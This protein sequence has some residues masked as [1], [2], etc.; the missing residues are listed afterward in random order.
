MTPESIGALAWEQVDRP[1]PCLVLA[2]WA[3][4]G[5]TAAWFPSWWGLWLPVF[6]LLGAMA[7]R[8]PGPSS[9]PWMMVM[10]PLFFAYGMFSYQ[11]ESSDRLVNQISELPR[12]VR[13]KLVPVETPGWQEAGGISGHGISRVLAVDSG[14]GWRPASGRVWT[15]WRGQETRLPSYG[16]VAVAGGFLE[17]PGRPEGPGQLDF[18]AYLERKGIFLVYSVDLN[19]WEETGEFNG[20]FF[21]QWAAGLRT[22]MREVLE[23][24]MD[25]ESR[26]PGLM[27]AMLFGYRDGIA[28]ELIHDFTVTGTLHLFAVSG[29]NVGVVLGVFLLFLRSVGVIRWRWGWVAAPALL[30]F[31]LATGMESSAARA[32]VMIVL[33]LLA[34]LIYRP[35]TPLNILGAAALILW[36]VDPRQLADAGF[37]LSFLVLLGLLWMGRPL[38]RGLYLPWRPDVFVPRSRL[39][40]WRRRFDHCVAMSCVLLASSVV[41]WV[42]SAPLIAYLFGLVA[43]VTVLSN[44]FV[45]PLA[46]VVVVLALGSVLVG[47]VP[48]GVAGLINQL[49]AGV[50]WVMCGIIGQ[51]ATVPGGHVYLE[52]DARLALDLFKVTCLS[53]R[54]MVAAIWQ[55]SRESKVIGVGNTNF[56]DYVLNPARQY[57]GIE[58]WESVWVLQGNEACLGAVPEMLSITPA[59]RVLLFPGSVRS[60]AYRRWEDFLESATAGVDMK[61]VASGWTNGGAGGVEIKVLWPP[62]GEQGLTAQDGGLVLRFQCG[63][64]HILFAG[65]A[66]KEVEALILEREDVLPVDVL[67]Q[68][69]HR[70]SPNLSNEWIKALKPKMVVRADPGF[71]PDIYLSMKIRSH[72]QR[73]GIHLIEMSSVSALQIRGGNSGFSVYVWDPVNKRFTHAF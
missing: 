17:A 4:L 13:L 65:N 3:G 9:R 57:L 15:R 68:G 51:V 45:V 34:W 32:W 55:D 54:G 26:W 36:L 39:P 61:Q 44:F 40:V 19:D 31:C 58:R 27:A 30:L 41:A 35:V 7:W 72:L 5:L 52:R 10:A 22:Y 33:L 66:S 16:N 53:D 8:F 18:R 43:P 25:P 59:K 2:G 37:Q 60:P 49:N 47:W 46:S 23:R 20:W 28:G 1:V 48:L 56:W 42:A 24:G 38:A 12:T 21:L 71:Y 70:S 11:V 63:G 29:Q 6:L 62:D 14:S 64:N 73:Q 50:L 69:P 67:I